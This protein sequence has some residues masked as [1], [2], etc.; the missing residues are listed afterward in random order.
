MDLT[1]TSADRDWVR[2]VVAQYERQLTTYA[3]HILKDVQC[4]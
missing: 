3:V 1:R 4:V 2:S